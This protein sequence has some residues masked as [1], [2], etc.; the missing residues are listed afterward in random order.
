MLIGLRV[1]ATHSTLQK[2]VIWSVVRS[3][4]GVRGPRGRA[5]FCS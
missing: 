4:L 5:V 1:V 3:Q 2:M